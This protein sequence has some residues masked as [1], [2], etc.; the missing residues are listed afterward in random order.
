MTNQD[1]PSEGGDRMGPPKPDRDLQALSAFI[2]DELPGDERDA[3]AAR[4]AA[5]PASQATVDAYR[6]Q[7]NALRALFADQTEP[8]VVRLRPRSRER[9]LIAACFLV[10][11]IACGYLMHM[12]LPALGE[13]PRFAERA[14]IAY[15]VYA[16]EQRHAVEV[17]AS[18]QD[19]LVTWLSKRL[20]RAVTIPSLAEYGF[21]L[22]GGRLLPDEE[23][24]AAQ[25]MYQNAAGERL[26][27]YMTTA[28]IRGNDNRIRMLKDGQRTTF[29][30]AWNRVG[31][32][33][34][35]QIGEAKL[36]A[37][38]YDTCKE[39]GGDPKNW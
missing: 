23:G 29:Y 5:D 2:D 35:G 3:V 37:I 6:A 38:A 22:V 25:F 16:P 30:W 19:H 13:K 8:Q 17:A 4:I 7:D 1:R 20:N 18:Q 14:D 26:T 32:A 11:G 36:Q 31:Y 15:A 12:L 28:T 39:L 24:P 27:L 10:V 9:Y 34:S 21:Q 33:L